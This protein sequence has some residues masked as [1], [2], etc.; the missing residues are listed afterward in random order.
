[1]PGG[2][3]VRLDTHVETGYVIPPFYDSMIGK[4]ICWG[5]DR[6]EAI[7]RSLRALDELRI[8]GVVTTADFHKEILSSSTFASGRF[9]TA[10]VAE[11]TAS[12]LVA[13]AS[14]A[15]TSH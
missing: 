7:A 12:L 14:Q 6:E 9:N 2:F 4:L 5:Q 11:H 10:F 15:S 1:V 8:V 3:G 13:G